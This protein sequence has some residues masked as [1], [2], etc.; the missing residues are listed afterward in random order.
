MSAYSSMTKAPMVGVAPSATNEPSISIVTP[1]L[2]QAAFIAEALRSVNL[3]SYE[4][5]EHLVIDGMSTDGTIDLLRNV[6]PNEA[7]H[8]MLWTSEPDSG[9]SEALNKGFR[10]TT[11]EIVGWLN[12]D[13]RYRPNCFQQVVRAFAENPEVDVIYGDYLVI[14]ECG[15]ALRIRREIEFSAFILLYHR[16]LYIPTTATFFRRRIF[17]EENW[18]DERLQYAMDLDF[19]V[20]LSRRGYRF[21][22]VPNILADFRLH[23]KSKSCSASDKQRKEHRHVIDAAAALPGYLGHAGVRGLVLSGLGSIA[24]S[25][26]YFEKLLRGYYWERISADD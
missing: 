25:R 10:K 9:Q 15:K 26:R 4:N 14:D 1:S 11:G 13:D 5:C 17:E 16:V 7:K 18:L 24:S 23:P 3:Q 22:H 6:M 19:F 2:N 12:A 8:R 20:R 21:R